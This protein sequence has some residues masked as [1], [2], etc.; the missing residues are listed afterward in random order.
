MTTARRAPGSGGAL[1]LAT[2][3][4]TICFFAWS[5]LGPLGPDIQEDL[6]LSDVQLSAI[7]AVPVLL[8]SIMR[9]PLGWLT[10][11]YG[12]RLVFTL[13]M[14][15]TPLPLVGLAL[16][17]DAVAP[18]LILGFLL[19]FAGAAFAV[20][21]PFV[22]GWYPPERQGVTL[23]IYGMGMGGTVIAG[24]TA[25]GIAD[26]WGLAAP[27]WIAAALV[28]VTGVVF[29]LLARDARPAPGGGGGG[30]GMFAALAVFRTSPRA[31]ALTLFYFLSF[32]GFVAMFL[33]LPK[34]LTGEH[35]LT[36]ADA[37]ARAAGFALLAVIG[38]PLGGWLSD[39]IGAARVMLVS[40]V[41]VAVLA[42]VLAAAYQAMV[43]LTIACLTL[44]LALGLGMG[45]VFKLVPEWFPDRVGAVTGVVGAAGGLGG[46]FPPLVMGAIKS[47]TG[48]YALGFVL[49]ALVAVACLV[50]FR[51]LGLGA[52]GKPAAADSG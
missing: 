17:H 51:A 22:N 4:F 38:R 11:R 12:G 18:I 46:F 29:W 21:V 5:L 36:K 6:G 20:G 2:V 39:R 15:F 13:L 24:L 35:D 37:G 40:F 49:M 33:Y 28:A 50:V 47:A 1:A 26:A 52:L 16:W 45:A 42:A 30:P 48:G 23:G 14:A 31:W 3:A 7:V 27:F 32:G 8:G 44:A 10:D 25:P 41:A 19:G 43:P 34:L 9:I